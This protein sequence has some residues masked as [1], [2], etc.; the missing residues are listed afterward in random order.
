MSF[1]SVVIGGGVMGSAIAL[2]LSQAGQRVLVLE[3]SVP[4]AEA[5][6]AAGGILSPQM[7]GTEDGPLFR[8]GLAS[9][10]AYEAF[11]REVEVL[12]EEELGYS[13]C[14]LLWIIRDHE[15]ASPLSHRLQ[16]QRRLDL[17]VELLEREAALTLEP[18][19]TPSLG[20]ALHLPLEGRIDPRRLAA[21]LPKAAR[22]AGAT[23]RQGGVRTIHVEGGSAVG[24]EVEHE[25]IAAGAVILAA[26]AWT[27]LV[28]GCYLPEDAV[29]PVRG[30]MV[31]LRAPDVELSRTIFT[32]SGYVIPRGEGL[33]VAGS[34][35][36]RSGFDKK[37]TA[38]GLKKILSNAIEAV[39]T[40]SEAELVDAW[41]GL[42]PCPKDGLPL[43]GTSNLPGLY[44]AS[45]HHRNGI[46][47]TPETAR[48]LAHAVV[49]GE[50]PP[51]LAPFSPTRFGPPN[52]SA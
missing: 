21:A 15:D 43:I 1:D 12:A 13:R 22:A 7:E 34:T 40:L 23:Y 46:L 39:P 11:A 18:A 25:R 38:S 5:S 35:M 48:L 33:F 52:R 42:R 27:S 17:E 14:G 19:L 41:S 20:A 37:V 44:I 8:L 32:S 51:E 50:D 47:L 30:Q 29:A 3:R 6:S 49:V 28:G 36:E 2:R 24:V 45:G 9:R 26:G 10:D 4:G 16:W 31:A